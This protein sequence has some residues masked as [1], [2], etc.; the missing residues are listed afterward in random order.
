MFVNVFVSSS[1]RILRIFPKTDAG[2]KNK[3][4][5]LTLP[6]SKMLSP[7]LLSWVEI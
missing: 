5:T 6:A 1:H 4:F 7:S 3:V 2:K